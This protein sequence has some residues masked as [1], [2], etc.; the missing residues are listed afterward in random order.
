ML[1]V[2]ILIRFSFD[3][4]LYRNLN[5]ISV[6]LNRLS[7]NCC[8]FLEYTPRPRVFEEFKRCQNQISRL[9]TLSQ[10]G[11]DDGRV[12]GENRRTSGL[13]ETHSNAQSRDYTDIVTITLTVTLSPRRLS[14]DVVK[15]RADR[16][17]AGE[18]IVVE[19]GGYLKY[20]LSPVILMI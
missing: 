19:R 3:E 7:C 15:E 2:S 14:T 20:A 8:E 6:T 12:K 13:F 10:I 4:Y 5:Y 9:E 1:D 17:R 18:M 11:F 16:E